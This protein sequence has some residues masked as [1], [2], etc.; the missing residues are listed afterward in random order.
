MVGKHIEQPIKRGHG[1]RQKRWT[2][3]GS[4]LLCVGIS[5]AL[6]QVLEGQCAR[7][8]IMCANHATLP[9]RT[10]SASV[11]CN[12]FPGS[13]TGTIAV[14]G[15]NNVIGCTPTSSLFF[16]P[17]TFNIMAVA[18]TTAPTTR[19]CSWA[20]NSVSGSTSGS[21][22]IMEADGLPV[23]LMGFSIES[24]YSDNPNEPASE[25]GP[26][27]TRTQRNRFNCRGQG[28]RGPVASPAGIRLRSGNRGALPSGGLVTRV[29]ACPLT[30]PRSPKSDD[31]ASQTSRCQPVRV[32]SMSAR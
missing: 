19:S 16:T 32:G 6:P 5:L 25:D 28:M 10:C 2:V 17:G 7:G 13:S 3:L 21:F 4:L 26:R 29:L 9:Q 12:G 30:K 8:T 31:D 27:A 11:M 1:S 18:N 14:A 20:W 24:S 22:S 15:S 23:E